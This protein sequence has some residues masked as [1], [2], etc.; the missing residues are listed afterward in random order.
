MTIIDVTDIHGRSRHLDRIAAEAAQVDL[1]VVSGDITHFGGR[2]EAAAIIEPLARRARQIVAVAGNCDTEEVELYLDEKGI[3][4]SGRSLIVDGVCF[5]GLG[6]SLPGP[7]RTPHTYSEEELA[8]LLEA[9]KRPPAIPLVL[10]AHHPPRDTRL[11][12]AGGRLHVGSF[13]VRSYIERERPLL[14][15][16]GHIHESSGLDKIAGCV[17][18]NPGPLPEGGYV[19]AVVE[20]GRPA[21]VAIERA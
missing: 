5:V 21:Q 12:M 7:M 13:S 14:C 8:A 19:R 2:A 15:L 11:D 20:D 1:L 17:I 6:G 4:L 10:V 3:N 16:T 18:V 9:A